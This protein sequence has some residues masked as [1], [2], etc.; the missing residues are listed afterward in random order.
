M[1]R[2]RAPGSTGSPRSLPTARALVLLVLSGAGVVVGAQ[3]RLV[4]VLGLGLVGVGCLLYAVGCAVWVQRALRRADLRVQRLTVPTAV[5]RGSGAQVHVR[6]T[7]R[8]IPRAIVTRTD[9]TLKDTV[10]EHLDARGGTVALTVAPFGWQ[11]S[12]AIAPWARGR[13]SLGPVTI[14]ITDPLGLVRTRVRD[15]GHST[16]AVRPRVVPLT[17]EPGAG[18]RSG[19]VTGDAFAAGARVPSPDDSLLRAY[20]PGDDVRRVHWPTTA[21]HQSL[22][23]RTDEHTPAP[24][25]NLVLDRRLV[26]AGATRRRSA[27]ATD[28]PV[29]LVASLGVAFA[30]RGRPVRLAATADLEVPAPGPADLEQ[31][32]E[33]LTDLA[34]AA[35]AADGARVVDDVLASRDGTTVVVLAA[36]GTAPLRALARLAEHAPPAAFRAL[37]VG[38]DD[39]ARRTARALADAGWWST[40]APRGAQLSVVAAQVTL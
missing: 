11:G 7:G 19:A 31:I 36:L 25:L 34:P 37:V 39:D 33:T 23:V 20:V 5:W 30:Q 9:A 4:T 16:L 1:S 22:M 10:D 13:W 38:D 29:D 32:L 27:D 35:T 6:V 15:L 40:V 8:R 26:E 28:W 2:G 14:R 12:Y 21:R 17:V 3:A 18:E 24:P